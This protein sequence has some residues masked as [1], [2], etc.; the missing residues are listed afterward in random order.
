M[1]I[2]VSHSIVKRLEG[3]YLARPENSALGEAFCSFSFNNDA[4]RNFLP[5]SGLLA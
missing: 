3:H 1:P 2:G 4:R 5:D